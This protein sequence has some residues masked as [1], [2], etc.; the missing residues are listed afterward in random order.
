MKPRINMESESGGLVSGPFI[1]GA[2]F[3]ETS[4]SLPPPPQ[5]DEATSRSICQHVRN[6]PCGFPL[7]CWITYALPAVPR[8]LLVQIPAYVVVLIVSLRS[9]LFPLPLLPHSPSLPFPLLLLPFTLPFLFFPFPSYSSPS[10]F[11]F[12]PSSHL[13]LLS[14]LV[15]LSPLFYPFCFSSPFPPPSFSFSSLS[16]IF[17]TIPSHFSLS[18]SPFSL[19]SSSPIPTSSS[20]S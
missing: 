8:A 16:L 10:L 3:S 1:L 12:S 17:S 13:S 11:T 14:S 18:F 7:T 4:L 5:E 2:K 15:L 19:S 20:N 9:Q 6:R